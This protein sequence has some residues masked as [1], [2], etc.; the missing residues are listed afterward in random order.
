VYIIFMFDHILYT[1]D[2]LLFDKWIDR[3][4]SYP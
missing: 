1:S 4:L 2:G 3:R